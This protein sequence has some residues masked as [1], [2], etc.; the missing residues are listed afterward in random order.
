[1]ESFLRYLY[2]LL[3][4]PL[5]PGLD[6]DAQA[7]ARAGLLILLAF[8]IALAIRY[9]VLN[10][11][12]EMAKRSDSIYDSV[13]LTLLRRRTIF[14]AVLL[15]MMS[16][17]PMLPWTKAAK[18]TGERV[19]LALLILSFTLSLIRAFKELLI[20]YSERTGT[21]LGRTTLIRY[22][23]S[24]LLFV[25]GVTII[26][27]LFDISL[28]P[29]I[30]ALGIGGLAVALAFQDTLAN[31]FAGITMTLSRQIR[32]GDYLEVV[33]A[34][35]GFVYDISWRTTTL[36]TV[37]NNMVIIPNKKLAE[38]ILINH[39]MPS[40]EGPIEI[41]LSVGYD[42]DPER[43][44][45][46]LIDEVM[47]A[48]GSVDG[49]MAEPPAVRFIEFGDS[50]LI[51]KLLPQIDTIEAQLPARH[52]LMK[53]VFRRLREEGI[54]IP[55]PIRTLRFEDGSDGEILKKKVT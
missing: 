55:Y 48:V 18:L 33:D 19:I 34:Q 50:A 15:A 11:L 8:L 42:T 26:L 45:A 53:R 5:L 41:V 37:A 4:D 14:W 21:V 12:S 7:Y 49:V 43:L 35:K 20:S 3:L 2:D 24:F 40:T 38:S 30:T 23:G 46:I 32:L 44:E 6:D 13:I 29:A 52:L 51:V 16:A 31:L 25:L 28:V 39:S 9:V 22:V 47:S 1:M 17:V 36:R 27:S 10:R 54:T